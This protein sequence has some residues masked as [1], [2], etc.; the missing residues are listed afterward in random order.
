MPGLLSGHVDFRSFQLVN[1]YDDENAYINRHGFDRPAARDVSGEIRYTMRHECQVENVL[2]Q[3]RFL[4][5]LGR[6]SGARGTPLR[7]PRAR[8][9]PRPVLERSDRGD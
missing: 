3:G 1:I 2:G 6:A 5:A 9:T 4:D 8:W 7:D